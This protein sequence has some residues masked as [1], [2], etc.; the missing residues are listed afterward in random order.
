MAVRKLVTLEPL[1]SQTNPTNMYA[2]VSI[3]YI[4]AV[5]G[6]AEAA[7]PSSNRILDR[8]LWRTNF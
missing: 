8:I 7:P 3:N 5:V 6:E 4:A 1:L 2:D